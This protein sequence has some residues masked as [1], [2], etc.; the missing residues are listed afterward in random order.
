MSR[1]D[2]APYRGAFAVVPHITD[3]QEAAALYVGGL[4]NLAVQGED[5]V[6]V[7]FTAVPVG[8]ILPIRTRRVY[9]I[10]TTA[11]NIVGFKG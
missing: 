1:A 7:T 10:G 6:D 8:T 2:T 4:G 11:T 5:G 3:I 9:A